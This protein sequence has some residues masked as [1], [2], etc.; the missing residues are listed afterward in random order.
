MAPDDD[1]QPST[2]GESGDQDSDADSEA[3]EVGLGQQ[4]A[5]V[6][7]E[8]LVRLKQD[9]RGPM[10]DEARAIAAEVKLKKFKREHKNRPMETTSKRPVGRFRE[11]IQVPKSEGKDPRFEELSGRLDKDG[12]KK[13]YAFLYDQVLPQERRALKD[14]LKKESGVS[15]KTRLRSDL[16]KIEQQIHDEERRRKR[17][18]LEADWKAEQRTAVKAG[19][20]PYYLKKSA[21][22]ERELLLRYEELKKSGKLE[23]YMEK[24]RKKNAAKDHRYLPSTRRA[25]MEA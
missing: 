15:K 19:K 2:S 6:P 8:V 12:F 1:N 20:Q 4:V 21:Q 11:V 25:A 17:T 22:K 7:F 24:R 14:R 3:D 13:R 18:K 16:T 5:H 9:G 23:K 10:G